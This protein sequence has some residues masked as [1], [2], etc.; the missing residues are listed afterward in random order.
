MDM[1]FLA[2]VWRATG[3]RG[4]PPPVYQGGITQVRNMGE[5][6]W[7]NRSVHLA[8]PVARDLR[9]YGVPGAS[10]NQR[11]ALEILLHEYAHVAQPR[12]SGTAFR[13][14]GAEA[15]AQR[16]FPRISRQFGGDRFAPGRMPY[17]YPAWT[18][19]MQRNPVARDYGQFGRRP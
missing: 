16:N 11:Q 3:L 17:A 9:S 7:Y 19:R 12:A 8:E 18:R 14:G 6:P 2:N 1:D 15:W 4:K 5:Q 10:G 13:E